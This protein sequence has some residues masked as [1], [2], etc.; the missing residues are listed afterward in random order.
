MS[1]QTFNSALKT[2]SQPFMRGIK[3][4][5]QGRPA[6]LIWERTG[7]GERDGAAGVSEA[8]G[9]RG[10]PGVSA[11][12][13]RQTNANTGKVKP[14]HTIA[15]DGLEKRRAAPPGGLGKP[16][17]D[18]SHG[19]PFRARVHG[20]IQKKICNCLFLFVA[21]RTWR[22]HFALTK[23]NKSQAMAGLRCAGRT[24]CNTGRTTK[25][26]KTRMPGWFSGVASPI[27]HS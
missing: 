20:G 8:P 2:Y 3:F 14:H 17:L 10:I 16:V 15:H 18:N 25:P 24:R 19:H 13:R 1:G 22:C 7:P 6:A 21:P 4:A 12:A 26:R 11:A 9:T 27:S 23:P 5:V